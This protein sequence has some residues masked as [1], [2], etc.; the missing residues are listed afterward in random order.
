M[1]GRLFRDTPEI[2]IPKVIVERSTKRVLTTEFLEG[3]DYYSMLDSVDRQ[4]KNRYGLNMA[5]F[6]GYSLYHYG[7]FN[8]DPH[9]GNYIFMEDGKVGFLDFGSVKIFSKNIVELWREGAQLVLNGD[10][11]GLKEWTIRAGITDG[12]DKRFDWDYNWDLMY[13]QHKPY[14]TSDFEYTKEYVSEVNNYFI[15]NKN[16]ASAKIPPEWLFLFRFQ[17]GFTSLMA[18][19]N[20]RNDWRSNM[21]AIWDKPYE[22]IGEDVSSVGE[23][24]REKIPTPA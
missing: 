5:N 14:M 19:L 1:F 9:P 8:A 20:V 23:I 3:L 24:Y 4:A 17:F 16:K 10:R 18:D 12:N 7:A 21:D 6:L 13:I 11:K 2:I 22:G 15:H